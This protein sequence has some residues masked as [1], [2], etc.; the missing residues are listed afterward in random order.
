V[1][2]QEALWL[3][4]SLT[5]NLLD[6]G[7]VREALSRALRGAGIAR[8]F[9][10]HD[11]RHTYASLAIQRGVPVVVVSRQ[12]GHSSVAITDA[13]YGHL[14]P[15]ATREAALAWEAILTAPGR[16]LGATQT[17]IPA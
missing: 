7:A 5:G 6:S 4:P 2:G 14:A 12:L 13:V 10:I 3:F 11:C 16:N 8:R 1:R 17:E 9:R 15:E